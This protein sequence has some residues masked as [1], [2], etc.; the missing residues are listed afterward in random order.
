MKHADLNKNSTVIA[1]WAALFLAML[2]AGAVFAQTEDGI[3]PFYGSTGPVY[4][5]ELAAPSPT[6]T[7][8]LP[9]GYKMVELKHPDAI[10]YT[11]V[12]VASTWAVRAIKKPVV[13]RAKVG[14]KNAALIQSISGDE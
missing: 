9:E 7:L 11:A 12:P 14:D 6:K 13:Y 2:F 8:D 5:T 3:T 1:L 10:T 4:L